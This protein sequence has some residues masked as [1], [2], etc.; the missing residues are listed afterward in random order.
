MQKRPEPK[1]F[2]VLSAQQLTPHM[3][4]VSIGGEA[5]RTFPQAQDGGYV[6]LMIPGS[7]AADPPSVRTFTIRRQKPDGLDIDFALHGGANDGGPGMA[8]ARGAA[9]GDEIRV[10]GPGPAKILPPGADSY[11]VLGDMTA[12]PA[13]SVNLA[14]LADDAIGYVLIEI[15]N[16][17]DKQ[18]IKHPEGI[19]V[20]WVVNS[21]P[22]QR[23]EIFEQA[24]RSV[25]WV[26][27][28]IYAWSATEFNVMKRMRRYLREERGLG[29]D[30]LYISSYWKHGLVEDQHR[31][32]KSADSEHHAASPAQ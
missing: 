27:G 17:A 7:N 20:R 11:L 10:G 1:N 24:V 32:A 14:A 6:K 2:E 19:E 23:P 31:E 18:D 12:L 4:R 15:Q 8:W 3:R 9:P 21:D 30:Q 16:E 28:R 26:E 22:G 29:S 5:I 25:G 13:I